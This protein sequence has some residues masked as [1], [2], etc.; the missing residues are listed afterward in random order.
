MKDL[1]KLRRLLMASEQRRVAALA[2]AMIGVAVLEVLG[3]GSILPFMQLLADPEAVEREGWLRRIYLFFDFDSV[4]DALFASGAVLFVAITATNLA[5]ATTVWFRERLA[6]DL[7]HRLATDVLRRYLD[8]PYGFFLGRNT[9]NLSQTLLSEVGYVVAGIVTP[10]LT[11]AA[12]GMSA[13]LIIGLLTVF[14]W[15]LALAAA[16]VFGGA[17][18]AVYSFFRRSQA[19]LGQERYEQNRLRFQI[20]SEALGGIKDVKTLGREGEFMRRFH[21]P[22]R[23]FSDA[24][25]RNNLVAGLPRYALEVVGLGGILLVVLYLLRV[26]ADLGPV[27]PVLTLY[28]FAAY[29]LMPALNELFRSVV[30]IR[31]HQAGL[32]ALYVDL[33][34]LPT[35]Q[36]DPD[37]GGEPE[38]A[39]ATHDGAP[40]TSTRLLELRGVGFRHD[41]RG[42]PTLSGIDL[43]I[44][45]RQVVGFVGSTGAGKTTLIDVILGLLEPS[46]GELLVEGRPLDRRGALTWRTRCGYVPQEIFLCDD[47]VTANI[48]FGIPIEEID[49]GAVEA[50]ARMA[51][52]HDFVTGLDEGYG[53][54][55]GERGVRLSGGERQRIGI[56]RALYH[57]P[58]LLVLDEAT[59]A[60]DGLTEEGVMETVA[61]LAGRK[62]VLVIAHRFNTVRACD[63]IHLLDRGRIV[64]SGSFDELYASNEHFRAMA[65]RS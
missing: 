48:A 38:R 10:L 27:V 33:V 23:R 21:E 28:A 31:F 3:V 16:A 49:H 7:N 54:V 63:V 13:L 29:R 35:P 1:W 6:W 65:G 5:Y 44:E 30:Q 61:R 11:I 58:E 43:S 50:A 26:R 39:E 34:E 2:V 47:T 60:L 20:A 59:N 36:T 8:Q 53:T 64:A 19:R 18:G 40:R 32:D 15:R 25:A 24:A 55:V 51:R 12:R 17:Y 14:D 46:E 57:D 62:T 45:P 41:E 22:S 56:A 4:E 52:L 37:G 42:G 9:S